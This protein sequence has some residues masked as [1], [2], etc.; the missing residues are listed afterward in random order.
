[1]ANSFH[2]WLTNEG[3]SIAIALGVGIILYI[4]WAII[5]Y[6]LTKGFTQSGIQ[7]KQ[8]QRKATLQTKRVGSAAMRK[9]QDL[10]RVATHDDDHEDEK[11]SSGQTSTT[12]DIDTGDLTEDEKS[13]IRARAKTIVGVIR[14]IGNCAIYLIVIIS[15]M[16]GM[17]YI[18]LL[19]LYLIKIVFDLARI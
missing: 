1:M 14:T 10:V 19:D 13:I 18:Y 11:G 5:C 17:F 9:S 7:S 4:I 3:V 2:K 8:L 15:I 6:F 16:D 12:D